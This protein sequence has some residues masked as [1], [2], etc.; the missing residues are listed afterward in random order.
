LNYWLLLYLLIHF[1]LWAHELS[2]DEL[3][4]IDKMYTLLI[5]AVTFGLWYASGI[6]SLL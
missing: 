6:L 2:D 3:E 4:P 5:I 1:L